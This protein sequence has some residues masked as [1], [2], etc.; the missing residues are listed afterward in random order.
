MLKLVDIN[1]INTLGFVQMHRVIGKLALLSINCI[2]KKRNVTMTLCY[3]NHL[4]KI[5]YLYMYMRSYG[6]S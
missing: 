5:Y 1:K 4:Y 3:T 2:N 6:D